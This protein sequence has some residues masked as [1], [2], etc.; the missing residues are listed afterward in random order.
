MTP[1]EM[2]RVILANIEATRALMEDGQTGYVLHTQ[3]HMHA[4]CQRR[5]QDI[6]RDSLQSDDVSVFTT[7]ANAVVAQ[8]YWNSMHPD[9]KVKIALRREAL[10]AYIDRQQEAVDTLLTLIEMETGAG[11]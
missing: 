11:T 3:D 2:V 10:V 9:D 7:H 1:T 5:G 8:R 4:L 6:R